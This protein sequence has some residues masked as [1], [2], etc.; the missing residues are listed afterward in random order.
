MRLVFVLLLVF[1]KHVIAQASLAERAGPY[2][3][4]L[5]LPSDGLFAQE[6]I[7]VAFRVTSLAESGEPA[8][9]RSARFRCAIYMPSMPG[10]PRFEEFAH[11]HGIAGEYGVHPTFPH[12][13]EYRMVITMSPPSGQPPAVSVRNDEP[14]TVEFPLQVEDATAE[15]RKRPHALRNPYQLNVTAIPAAPKAGEEV[16]LRLSVTLLNTID[17]RAATEFEM[18]HE[19]VMHV[20]LVRSD[21][22]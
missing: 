17:R 19:K 1:S 10:M 2:E 21:L 22:G 8:P 18:V 9:A 6:E 14:F 5:R 4:T 20:F 3:F 7:E 13:G 12:G 15:S 16:E 11:S